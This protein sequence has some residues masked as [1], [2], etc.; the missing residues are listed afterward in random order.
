[1]MICNDRRWAEAWRVLSLQG[2]E[3]VLC[4][5]N[6]AGY[7]PELWGSDNK[8]SPKEAEEIATFQHQLSMQGHGYTNACFSVSA[9][10]A[11]YD[12]G[13]F[14]MIGGSCITDPEGSI[15]AQASTTSDEL[16]VA[17]CD[18]DRCIPGKTRTFD[19]ARHRRIEHYGRITEQ[20]GVIEPPRLSTIKRSKVDAVSH[21]HINDGVLTNGHTQSPLSKGYTSG[22]VTNGTAV[23]THGGK[24]LPHAHCSL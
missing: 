20:A 4:G 21:E 23:T 3:V 1:M 18:L 7:A 11:G 22:K 10:H 17:D 16:V 19:F 8:Q 15:L 24:C 14:S 5:Y 9:G 12:D 13:K 6:T 2:T